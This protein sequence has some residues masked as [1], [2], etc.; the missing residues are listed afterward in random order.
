MSRP[1]GRWSDERVEWTLGNLLRA[2]VVAAALVVIAGGTLYLTRHGGEPTDL[3]V[4]R[5]EPADL[6]VPADIVRDALAGSGRG[7]IALGLLLLI[8]TP[9][10][11]VAMAAYAFARQRDWLYLAVAAFV[12]A[13]LLVSLVRP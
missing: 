3:H 11:R 4:F 9:A 13:V 2:G 12:L 10:A 6:R 5:G 8:A 1:G 7:V